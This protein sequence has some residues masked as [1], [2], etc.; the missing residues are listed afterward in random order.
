V[1][2]GDLVS[3]AVARVRVSVRVVTP[4]LCAAVHTEWCKCESSLRMVNDILFKDL[5]AH[6][7]MKVSFTSCCLAQ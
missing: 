1:V 6:V 3:S 5:F 2:V 7:E 4:V